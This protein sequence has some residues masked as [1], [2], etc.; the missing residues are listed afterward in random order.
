MCQTFLDRLWWIFEASATGGLLFNYWF[1][2]LLLLWPQTNVPQYWIDFWQ[3]RYCP[4]N[5]GK[6]RENE[7]GLKWSGKSQGILTVCP[8]ME[9]YHSSVSTWWSQFLPK[10]YIK[11]SWK[12][13]WS[14]WKWKLEKNGHPVWE[15]LYSWVRFYL[16]L[17]F[18]WWLK[19][20]LGLWLAPLKVSKAI[21]S[22]DRL[23]KSR[24]TSFCKFVFQNKPLKGIW[25]E[26]FIFSYESTG[27]TG[28]TPLEFL[29]TFSSSRDIS[30]NW[31]LKSGSPIVA[32]LVKF[33]H[34]RRN[35]W[36]RQ[37]CMSV[38]KWWNQ[39]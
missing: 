32:T 26:I 18:W 31:W 30:V 20:F 15:L 3:S 35:L 23:L 2:E 27:K 13:F 36:F 11:N 4:G 1:G 21:P 33:W 5:Q 25:N 10:R 22:L 8:N 19:F 16:H 34:E 12:I 38:G 7:K 29:D 37:I 9:V 6:V 39:R 28:K 14:H 17:Y 24:N